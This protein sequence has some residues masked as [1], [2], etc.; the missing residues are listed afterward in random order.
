MVLDESLY[1]PTLA[2]G[3]RGRGAWNRVLTASAATVKRKREED[4]AAEVTQGKRKLRR[5]MS[6]KLGSQ[7]ETMWADIAAAGSG[8]ARQGEWQAQGEQD[9]LLGDVGAQNADATP[10]PTIEPTRRRSDMSTTTQNT[11]LFGGALIYI[12]GF[13]P[14]KTAILSTH[15]ESHGAQV[16]SAPAA[17]LAVEH[18]ERGFIVIPHDVP[19]VEL[20]RIPES[21]QTLQCVTEWWV[22]S[23][24]ATKK[25]VHPDQHPLCRPFKKLH[26]DGVD[27]ELLD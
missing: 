25:M 18:V 21:A 2:P 27:H 8:N 13:P 4:K 6:A 15:L 20:P 24:L 16:C 14:T 5:T 1:S 7:H 12:H 10:D 19:R 17:L 9:S 3:D 11:S 23:C 22:E 26:I